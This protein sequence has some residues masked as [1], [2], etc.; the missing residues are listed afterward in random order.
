MAVTLLPYERAGAESRPRVSH[1]A[2]RFRLRDG[3]RR[4]HQPDVTERLREVAQQLASR[5]VHLLR[6]EAD[7]V[8]ER[9]GTAEHLARPRDIAAECQR[10]GQPEG[11]EEEAALLPRETVGRE[12]PIDQAV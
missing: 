1:T 11:I 12:V 10:M 3:P 2:P 9:R 5:R 8:D 6:Q 7:V 4:V